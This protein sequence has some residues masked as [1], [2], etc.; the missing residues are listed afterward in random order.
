MRPVDSSCM[1]ISSPPRLSWIKAQRDRL[2]HAERQTKREMQTG[3]THYVWGQRYRLNASQTAGRYQVKTKGKT[4][5]VIAPEASSADAKRAAL[6]RWYRREL[7]AALPDVLDKW[8][9]TIG[10]EADKVVVR[11][12]KTKWGSCIPESATIAVNPELAKKDPRSLEY[13]VVHELIHLLE[14]GHNARFTEL[15][16]EYLPDWRL[17]RDELNEAPLADEEWRVV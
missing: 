10:V 11:R 4:L 16:D 1:M 8:Q 9:S 15:M 7:K 13:I 5:W 14:R 12:M 17:R 3:E 6:D 2:Q